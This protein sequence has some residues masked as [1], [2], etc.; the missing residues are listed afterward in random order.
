MTQEFVSW[1]SNTFLEATGRLSHDIN[2][3][4]LSQQYIHSYTYEAC[5]SK[6]SRDMMQICKTLR[7]L[8]KWPLSTMQSL[9]DSPFKHE[10]KCF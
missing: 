5:Q 3:L 7:A 6:P 8:E 4:H 9:A 1:V 2:Q 10:G